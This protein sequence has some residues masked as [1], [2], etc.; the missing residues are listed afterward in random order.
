MESKVGMQESIDIFII[1]QKEN[2]EATTI[3][4]VAERAFSFS[5]KLEDESRLKLT[6]P[7]ITIWASCSSKA[8][9]LRSNLPFLMLSLGQPSGILLD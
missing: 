2:K 3:R 5:K 7:T 8:P 9:A 6:Y 1:P 4:L